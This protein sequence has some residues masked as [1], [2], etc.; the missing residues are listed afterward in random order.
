[1]SEVTGSAVT[2]TGSIAISTNGVTTQHAIAD[3][4]FWMALHI[5]TQVTYNLTASFSNNF[6]PSDI[7]S[8]DITLL[9]DD[10][11]MIDSFSLVG[12]TSSGKLVPGDYDLKARA[13]ST[14]Q[15]CLFCTLSSSYSIN[16]SVVPIPAAV[17]LF[18]T[19]LIGLIGLA[20]RKS[21]VSKWHP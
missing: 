8:L 9:K 21:L 10:A 12:G 4:S 7:Q 15:S 13:Y 11:Q 16:F 17:W 2:A 18:G 3:S 6:D 19:A 20:T 1:M 5:D 14:G